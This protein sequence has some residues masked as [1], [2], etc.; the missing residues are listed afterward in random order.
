MIWSRGLYIRYSKGFSWC[1]G[2]FLTIQYGRFFILVL[3]GHRIE[4]KGFKNVYQLKGGIINYLKKI[5]KKNSLWRGECYVFDNRV[6]IKHGLVTGSYS[7]CSG[8]RMPISHKDKKKS[9][10]SW[11]GVTNFIISKDELNPVNQNNW[12]F[13]PP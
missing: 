9:P 1:F 13:L 8:C 2:L 5:K 11:L 4:K 7:M 10:R 6:S 12:R 3:L